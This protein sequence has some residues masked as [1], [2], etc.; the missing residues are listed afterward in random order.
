[1]IGDSESFLFSL[2]K[3]S[4][5]E[6]IKISWWPGSSGGIL[7]RSDCGPAFGDRNHYDLLVWSGSSSYLSLGNSFKCPQNADKQNY[8]TGKSPFGVDEME[9][10][11]IDF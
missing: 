11:K 10:F 9:V 7:C 8:F 4:G 2:V 3:P 5:S 6:P 1:M